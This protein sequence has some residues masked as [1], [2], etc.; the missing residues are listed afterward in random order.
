MKRK[1]VYIP[2]SD[3]LKAAG[4]ILSEK[5]DEENTVDQIKEGMDA[6]IKLAKETFPKKYQKP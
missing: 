1:Y 2:K 6:L 4:E 3:I 5:Y